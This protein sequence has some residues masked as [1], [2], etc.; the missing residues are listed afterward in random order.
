MAAEVVHTK[1]FQD[2]VIEI[3]S[4]G[5]PYSI[6]LGLITTEVATSYTLEAVVIEVLVEVGL[7]GLDRIMDS[8]YHLIATISNSTMAYWVS[9]LAI[10]GSYSQIANF[11]SDLIRILVS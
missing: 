7:V 6:Y 2:V 11:V 8:T 4:S 9:T 1:T 10:A 5:C 3:M